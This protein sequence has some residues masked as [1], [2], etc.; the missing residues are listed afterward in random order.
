MLRLPHSV[1]DLFSEWLETHYPVRKDKVLNALREVRDGKLYNADFASRMRGTGPR[2]DYIESLFQ[3]FKQ[4]YFVKK[5]S[6]GLRTD[7]FV[8]PESKKD[9][10]SFFD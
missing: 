5:H 7:L 9:Q 4:K 2:A 8:R 10:F 1:K 6:F 3:M